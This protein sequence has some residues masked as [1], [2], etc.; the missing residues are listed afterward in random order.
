MTAFLRLTQ[1]RPVQWASQRVVFA[2][3]TLLRDARQQGRAAVSLLRTSFW[4]KGF[5]LT[6]AD[7]RA[8]T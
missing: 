1:S 4:W 2:L 5:S 6:L 7:A 3:K 8:A